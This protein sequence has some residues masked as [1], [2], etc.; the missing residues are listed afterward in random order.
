[1][2]VKNYVVELNKETARLAALPP[3]PKKTS[4]LGFDTTSK[5]PVEEERTEIKDRIK[6]LKL[7]ISGAER[8]RDVWKPDLPAGI[9]KRFE[10]AD[11]LESKEPAPKTVPPPSKPE[12]KPDPKDVDIPI[13]TDQKDFDKKYESG[14]SVIGLD[15]KKYTKPKKK[16]TN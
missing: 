4:L 11:K 9:A 6:N 14:I 16:V 12:P 15:G 3:A 1:M 2:K 10:V 13:A 7:R 5:D 8:A